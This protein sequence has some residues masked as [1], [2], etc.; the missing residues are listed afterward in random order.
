MNALERT[1]NFINHKPVDRPPFHPIIMRFAAKYARVPY[2]EFC[3][4]YQDKC[5]AMRKCAEDF[6]LDWVTV[7]SD[8]W[9]EA[10]AFG[11]AFEY[12]AN[13]LP[14]P[15]APLLQDLRA[16]DALRVPRLAESPRML[17]RIH[18]I[19][20]F[21]RQVGDQYFIVGWVEGPMAEFADLRGLSAACTDLYDAPQ[22]VTR[23]ADIILE[24]ALQFI[25]AQVRAGAHC[26]GIGDAACS[27]IGPKLYR[28]FFWEREKILVEHIHSLGALA[29]LHICGKTTA[30]LPEMIKTGADIVDVDHLV[31]SMVPFTPLLSDDQVLSGNSDP[32]SVIQDGRRED[33][34]N[35]VRACLQ[36]TN[37]RGIVSAGCE[38]TP[39]TS[40]ENF[41]W[42]RDAALSL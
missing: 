17:N 18:E 25:T 30:I 5:F 34:E 2:R 13:D 23:A 37:G 24:N 14:K 42:Y 39:D 36:Q 12:P 38:I 4:N 19:E 41:G 16:V 21:R 40:L 8:P 20:E 10:E 9:V 22:E 29:K 11:M 27:V 26:I 1:L 7:M 15:K 3:L 35:S 32:V 28:E 6:T 33:I 31:L